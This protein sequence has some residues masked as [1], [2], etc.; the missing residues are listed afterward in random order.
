MD[1]S[2]ITPANCTPEQWANFRAMQQLLAQEPP[3]DVVK[4]NNGV[5]YLP[6]SWIQ[7][8]LDEI[9][10]IWHVTKLNYSAPIGNEIAVT[11][12]LVVYIPALGI[13]REVSGSAALMIQTKSGMPAT[14]ENKISN[15]L[16]KMIPK[17]KSM[18][19]KNAAKSLGKLFGQDLGRNV[20]SVANYSATT[21]AAFDHVAQRAQSLQAIENTLQVLLEGLSPEAATASIAAEFKALPEYLRSDKDCVAIFKKAKATFITNLLPPANPAS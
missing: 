16:E 2:Q 5:E 17:G 11:L 13:Y 10:G 21:A 12:A 18:A 1:F 6:T 9:F 4:T 14:P 7:K 19:F 3:R 15:T 8:K 20:N